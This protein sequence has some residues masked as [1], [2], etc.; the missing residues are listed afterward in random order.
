MSTQETTVGTTSPRVEQFRQSIAETLEQKQ[1][2]WQFSRRVVEADA[3]E[4]DVRS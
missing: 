2:Q 4:E 3:G 1:Y